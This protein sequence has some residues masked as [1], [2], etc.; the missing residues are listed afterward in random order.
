[1]TGAAPAGRTAR[2]ATAAGLV[3]GVLPFLAV[4]LSGTDLLRTAHRFRYGS[5]FFDTQARALMD[6]HLWVPEGS[7]GIEGFE[8]G[9]RTY[10]YFPPFPALLRIPVFLVT[11]EFDGRLSLLS[12]AL[13]FGV[14]CFV[15]ARL[16]WL[17]RWCLRGEEPVGRVEA[18]AVAGFLA[19]ATGGTVLTFDAALPW[20][21]HEVYLW[22]CAL[23][24]S[25]AYLL[26]RLV[27]EPAPARA[28]WLAAVLAATALTRT[29]GGWAMCLVAV[30]AGVW[31]WTSRGDAARRRTGPWLAG[32][33]V[34]ALGVGVAVNMAKF[35]H[36]YLFPLEDQVWT[37]LNARR[38]EALEVNGGT[39]TGPQ[40]FLS[41]LQAYFRPDGIRFVDHLPF[42][43]LPAEPAEGVGGA[44][45]DQSYRTGSVTSFMTLLLL[46]SLASLPVVLAR[47]RR[48]HVS[49]LR[50][51]LL[52]TVLVTG[53]VMAY[54]YLTYRYTSEFVPALVLGGAIG[55]V[56]LCRTLRGVGALRRAGRVA[57]AATVVA[58]AVV[59]TASQVATGSQ[60]LAQTWRGD[61]LVDFL[62]LQHRLGGGPDGPVVGLVSRSD[63]LPSGGHADDLHVRGDC[64]AL[65]LHTGDRYEPWVLVEERDVVVT[66]HALESGQLPGTAR[67][68]DLAGVEQRY[69]GLEN[70][71]GLARL[72]IDDPF[73]DFYGP[74]FELPAGSSVE[75]R[76]HARSDTGQF[77]LTAGGTL[78]QAPVAEWTSDWSTASPVLLTHTVGRDRT[79]DDLGLR[80]D[81]RPGP[82]PALCSALLADLEQAGG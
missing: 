57:L 80:L 44:F 38:R 62:T 21:Y 12:M 2:V 70:Y 10:M 18:V 66:V 59:A 41:S 19:A 51:P 52:G 75:V 35:G 63:E 33:A 22:S 13:A 25:C 60:A 37:G 20:V 77:E 47:G 1:M 58:L 46:L 16:L 43:T 40:F 28:G 39:I 8:V 76:A 71:Q 45:V 79:L 50:L 36:P 14:F 30:V 17:V 11:D 65:Y 61:R 5:N 82:R 68:Y 24:L 9:G 69:V 26:V 72:V 27:L 7:L 4:L 78:L 53:G 15:A 48:T 73:Q 32:L 34:L 55:L 54:G 3:A 23:V 49:A 81:V 64:E 74:W 29:T 6:G 31:L 67:L 42:V 56:G